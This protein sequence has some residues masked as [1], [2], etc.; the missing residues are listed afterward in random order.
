MKFKLNLIALTVVF[1]LGFTV[2]KAQ[3]DSTKFTATHLQAAES[4]LIAT[5][6]NTQFNGIIDN[7]VNVIS[8]QIPENNRAAFVGVMKKFMNKYYTWDI[9]K[10][11]FSKMY[12]KE[13]T[14]SE[15]NQ[16]TVFY[17]SP[18]GK[19]YSGKMVT[20]QQQGMLVGQKVV[21]EHQSEL[22]QMMKDAMQDSKN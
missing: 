20:L 6:V 16:L 11:D 10:G 19:K 2:A 5:G 15:L 4:F 8:K 22:E 14:E 21:S 1:L 7:M 12:A 17:N 3:T 9:L 13:F 18:I